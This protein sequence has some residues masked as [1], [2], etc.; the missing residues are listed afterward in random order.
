ME[1]FHMQKEFW[2]DASAIALHVKALIDA[3]LSTAGRKD[4]ARSAAV[5]AALTTLPP[6]DAAPLLVAAVANVVDARIAPIDSVGSFDSPRVL[7]LVPV[8]SP[9]LLERVD[10]GYLLA[11]M[12]SNITYENREH[13][14]IVL[15]R[16]AVARGIQ[17]EPG[18]AIGARWARAVDADATTPDA[19]AQLATLVANAHVIIAMHGISVSPLLAAARSGSIWVDLRPPRACAS[20]PEYVP[21][22]RMLGLQLIGAMLKEKNCTADA[23]SQDSYEIDWPPIVAIVA[24]ALGAEF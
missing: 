12:A 23:Y 22:A 3:P 2:A 19:A 18:S 9:R 6:L 16:N 5:S 1:H 10:E 8:R 17:G 7:L 21:A 20:A 24:L 14:S 15:G 11:G 13:A 4:S